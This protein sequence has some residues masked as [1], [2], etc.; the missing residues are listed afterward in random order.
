MP[1]ASKPRWRALLFGYEQRGHPL[2]PWPAFRRRLAG[3]LLVGVG[4]LL[5]SLG[6]GMAGYATLAGL[7]ATDSFLNAA[8]ILSGMGP[9]DPLPTPAAKWFAGGY[10]IYSGVAV[11]A[12]AGLV[13][14]PVIH[15]ILHR[16]HLQDEASGET[17]HPRKKP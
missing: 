11:L 3:N 5:V 15:R 2:L 17:T 7:D 4:L 16:F 6:V 1:G 12:I 13:F 9:V 10:A 14:A 8:M